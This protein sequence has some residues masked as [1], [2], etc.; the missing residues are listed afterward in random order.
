[1][2]YE[3]VFSFILNLPPPV[4]DPEMF[5]RSGV[6]FYNCFFIF[7]RVTENEAKE[8]ARVPLNPA[9]RRCGRST[10]KLARL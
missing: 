1:M 10:R 9:R 2:G 3:A 8:H 6:L 7:C 5:D 4:E